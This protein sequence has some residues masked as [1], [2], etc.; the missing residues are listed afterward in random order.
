MSSLDRRISTAIFAMHGKH[1]WVDNV[2]IFCARDLIV[3]ELAVLIFSVA[4]VKANI[5]GHDISWE[6]IRYALVLALGLVVMAW[7][8]ALVLEFL[9]GRRRPFLALGKKPLAK[10]WV[11]SPSF[12]S[13]HAAIA[14]ALAFASMQMGAGVAAAFLCAAAFVAAG[15]VYVG[16]HYL[17]DVLA[18]AV[19]GMIAMYV[20]IWV[21]LFASLFR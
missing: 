19:V 5:E 4:S 9:I 6:G 15:R 7:G 12:P 3:L 21:M 11:P 20:M 14:F 8:L 2:A 10:F 13:S 17:S 18:G 1:P 16:V